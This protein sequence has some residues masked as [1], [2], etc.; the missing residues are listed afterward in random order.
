MVVHEQNISHRPEI[1]QYPWE[2]VNTLISEIHMVKQLL[3]PS[4][5]Q[6]F[7]FS[8]NSDKAHKLSIH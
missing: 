4:L 1:V 8:A 7:H 5:I 2:G 6:K 3:E